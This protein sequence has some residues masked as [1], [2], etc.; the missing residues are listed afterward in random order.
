MEKKI[1]IFNPDTQNLLMEGVETLAKAVGSTLGPKGNNVVIETPHGV[2]TVTKD[3]V[4]VASQISLADPV[5]NLGCDIVK[6]AAQKT[7]K[8]AGDGP[9]PLTSKILTPDGFVFMGDIKVG[10][11]INGTNRTLQKVVGVFPKGEKEVYEVTFSD[12]RVVEC[13]EDH[14]WSVVTHNGMHKTMTVRDMIS[15]QKIKKVSAKGNVTYGFYVPKTCV[16]FNRSQVP[17][18]PYILGLLLGDGSLSGTG[19]IELSL[20]IKKEYI[21]ENIPKELIQSVSFDEDR[22]YFRVKLKSSEIKEQLLELGLYGVNSFTKFIPKKYLYNSLDVREQLLQG[23]LDTDAHINKRGLFEFSTVSDTLA[24]DFQELVRGLGKITFHYV[25]DRKDDLG[26]YSDTPIHRISE[27][28]GY[29]HG[30]KIKSIKP[31]G[32]L[33]EMQCIKVSNPDSLYITDNYIPTHNTSTSIVL[34]YKLAK[35]GKKLIDKGHSPIDVKRTYEDLLDKSLDLLKEITLPV[36]KEDIEKIATISANNDEVLG[37]LIAD[38]VLAASSSGLVTMN[39]SKTSST[40]IETIDG[41]LV[42]RGFS[43]PY[44]ITNQEKGSAELENPLILITDKKIRS[45][46]EITP[47]MQLAHKLNRPLVVIADE[48]ESAALQLLIINKIHGKLPCLAIKAPAFG[49]RRLELLEDLAA[50]TSAKLVSEVKGE[51]IEEINESHFGTCEK[52]SSTSE[53][54]LIINPKKG[55]VEDRLANIK[56]LINNNPSEYD[57]LKLSE[58]ISILES[59]A[60]V[61]NVGASTETEL[62]ELK[63]RIDDALRATRAA[64]EK[65]YVVGGGYALVSIADSLSAPISSF[66]GTDEKDDAF[67]NSLLYPAELIRSNAGVPVQDLRKEY[68]DKGE[69]NSKTNKYVDLISDGVIDPALVTEQALKNAVSAASMILLSTTAI[70]NVDRKEPYSP[71]NLEDYM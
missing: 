25:R 35:E 10:D 52:I 5:Q 65:G 56:N 57:F 45:A 50:L 2:T 53:E 51:R 58:R 68:L 60:A 40:Y 21:I 34:A 6:Q 59:K 20:G 61:I 63:D 1:V 69:Y 31:T 44:F 32:R 71:G 33:V 17:I 54:T 8:V 48:I 18:D 46:S 16:D 37:K 11:T 15:S 12:G 64:S 42:D 67:I 14:L 62:K 9:Q 27:L 23:L 55:N 43:S 39:E 3:G 7:A 22:N 28:K 24:N 49:N 26:S 41:S 38:A 13:C 19:S 30:I 29:K 66:K 36:A 47:A 4:T 70:Y